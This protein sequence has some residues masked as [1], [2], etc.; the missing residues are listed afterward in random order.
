MQ[1]NFSISENNL[2]TA[3]TLNNNA[4]YPI[5]ITSTD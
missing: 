3:V 5:T 1:V 2:L 4:S